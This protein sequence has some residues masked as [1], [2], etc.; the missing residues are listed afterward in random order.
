LDNRSSSYRAV[1]IATS[2]AATAD[3][4]FVRKR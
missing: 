3:A 4:S 2:R 1:D